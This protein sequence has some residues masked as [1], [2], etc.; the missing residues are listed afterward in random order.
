MLK[1]FK[2]PIRSAINKLTCANPVQPRPLA[3]MLRCLYRT[4]SQRM[5]CS[6]LLQKSSPQRGFST[7]SVCR[8]PH[9]E[10]SGTDSAT[11]KCW[12]CHQLSNKA[13]LFCENTRCSVIQP[14]GQGAT[15]FDVLLDGSPPSFVVDA[16]KLRR[17][18]LK[19][20][21]AVHPDSF[22]QK[23]LIEHKLAEAQSSWINHAYATLKDPLQRA[24]YL[25]ELSG[26]PISEEDQITDPEL[27][28]QIM[29][30]REEIEAASTEAQIDAIKEHNDANIAQVTA[31]LERAFAA[32]DFDSA[33]QLANHL[34]YL[35]RVAQAVHT[36]E[37]GK[38]VVISH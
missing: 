31:S 24:K 18:F 32:K 12:R 5:H 13:S 28:M 34:Q 4:H 11:K 26:H 30:T 29:D 6:G 36:W 15:Y 7:Q 22:S 17:S 14:V 33:K 20:Q 27:L 35:R 10:S 25:L 1:Q 37:P 23:E 8:Q 38:P 19:L 2:Y 9:S 3:S 16:G 21:Q